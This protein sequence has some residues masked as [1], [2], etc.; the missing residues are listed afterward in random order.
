MSIEN[1]SEEQVARYGRFAEEPSPQELEEFF[2][3]TD[4][5]LEMARAKRNGYNRLGWAIW[6]P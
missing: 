4:T 2:R 5:A 1:L 3:L 6:S